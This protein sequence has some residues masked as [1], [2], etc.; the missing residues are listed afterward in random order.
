MAFKFPDK[1]PDEKLDYT[2]DWSRYLERDGLTISSVLWKI[3]KSD[4]SEIQFNDGYTFQN[5][6]LVLTGDVYR[7]LNGSVSS[8]N[9]ITINSGSGTIYVGHRV[10]NTGSSSPVF[11]TAVNGATLTLSK[12]VTLA[13]GVSLG[14]LTDGLRNVVIAGPTS[15]TTTI[16]LDKGF[17]NTTYTL[18]CQIT[19]T[20]S[21]KTSDN[22]VTERKVKL[23][24]RERI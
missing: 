16:V 12:A 3:Q 21:T 14:F 18:I 13:D 9:T 5:D 2:V 8:S 6:V 19:T 10:T 15:T 22:I 4:G 17:V 1:D 20:A 11:V 7:T 24:V 23:K